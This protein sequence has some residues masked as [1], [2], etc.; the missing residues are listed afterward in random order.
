MTDTKK[1]TVAYTLTGIVFIAIGL[2]VFAI[3]LHHAGP[4]TMPHGGALYGGLAA[5]GLG[6]LLMWPGKPRVLGRI[7]LVLGPIALFPAIYSIVGESEEVISL[8]ASDSKDS[9]VDLRLWIV[10]RED[11]AWVGMSR[12]K[13]IEHNLDGAELEM[14]RDGE[15]SCVKPV[16]HEDRP[17]ARAIHAMKYEKYT[18]AQLAAS[19]GLYPREATES[20]VVLRFDPCKDA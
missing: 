2:A 13:A 16:L 14:L 18:A 6:A 4:Y 15:L 12:E 17:T 11:G 19:I 7:A 9:P 10:D 8:Y 20:T 3:R 1:S 5:A